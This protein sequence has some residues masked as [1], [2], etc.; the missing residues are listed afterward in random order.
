M[1]EPQEYCCTARLSP[2]FTRRSCDRALTIFHG[3]EPGLDHL[4]LNMSS[5]RPTFMHTNIFFKIS[6]FSLK[7][8]VVLGDVS[9]LLRVALTH[10]TRYA[11]NT[12][13]LMNT[14]GKRFNIPVKPYVPIV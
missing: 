11:S 9:Q 10:K 6:W 2:S 4:S 12:T 8:F 14:R 3:K 7:S 5:D 13:T 1:L